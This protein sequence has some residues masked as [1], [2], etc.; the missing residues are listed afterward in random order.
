MRQMVV[1]SQVVV[2]DA[3]VDVVCFQEVFERPRPLLGLSFD[4]VVLD[5]GQTNAA[6][7]PAAEVWQRWPSNLKHDE[8]GR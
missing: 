2:N 1:E 7:S 4:L 8:S 6:S 3:V 5:L